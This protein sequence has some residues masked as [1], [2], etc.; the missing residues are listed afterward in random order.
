MLSAYSNIIVLEIIT[1]R[2]SRS[3]AEQHNNK[4]QMHGSKNSTLRFLRLFC[5]PTLLGISM[6]SIGVSRS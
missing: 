2:M 3:G 4:Q 1:M 6:R 5:M